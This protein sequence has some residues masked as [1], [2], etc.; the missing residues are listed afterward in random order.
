MIYAALAIREVRL[1][2]VKCSFI[3]A[4]IRKS[5]KM[6]QTIVLFRFLFRIAKRSV[7]IIFQCSEK[8]KGDN[9]SIRMSYNKCLNVFKHVAL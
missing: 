7:V 1:S 2:I 5:Y 4:R 3:L 8:V 6:F 9:P